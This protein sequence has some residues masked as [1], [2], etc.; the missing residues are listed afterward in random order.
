M[1]VEDEFVV[2]IGDTG[3]GMYFLRRGS[4]AV[5]I[6][7]PE[8]EEKVSWNSTL[9]KTLHFELVYSVAGFTV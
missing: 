9:M 5:I 8:G 3:N 2:R 7:T 1:F 4:C 6:V